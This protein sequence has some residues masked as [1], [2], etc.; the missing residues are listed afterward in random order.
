[1]PS[2]DKRRLA[3]ADE[4]LRQGIEQPRRLFALKVERAYDGRLGRLPR[5]A[6]VIEVEFHEFTQ[7]IA[8]GFTTTVGSG[9]FAFARRFG[10]RHPSMYVVRGN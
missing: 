9:T 8:V 6:L 4:V 10:A 5:Y 3:R 7:R 2:R 1:M